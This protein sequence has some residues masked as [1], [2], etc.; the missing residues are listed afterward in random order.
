MSKDEGQ[1][2]Q[3]FRKA[4]QQGDSKALA[5]LG[6]GYEHGQGVPQNKV[7]AYALLNLAITLNVPDL[8]AV[9]K[10]RASLAANMTAQ[11]TN[12][13]QA[14]S[15]EMGHPDNLLQA[16]DQYLAASDVNS[17]PG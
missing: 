2:V 4:A 10:E 16:L 11:E 9:S 14:L 5:L 13:G 6:Y 3:W 1:A 12:A 15:Q 8:D 17:R 7:V